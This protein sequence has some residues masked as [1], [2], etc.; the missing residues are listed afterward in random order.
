MSKKLPDNQA[1]SKLIINWYRDNPRDLPWRDTQDPY[2]IWLSEIILQQTRVAQ[3]MPYFYKFSEAYPTVKDLAM[4]PEEEVLRLWQGLGYYSRARNLHFC[5]KQ[6]W[7]ELGGNFPDN[8]K[9]LLKLKGVGSYTA[10]AISS[11]AFGEAKAVVDGNVFR[12]LSRFFG[13]QTDIATG[14]AKKEFEALANS[15]IPKENPGEFNQ[16]MMDFGSRQCTPRN[17]DCEACP[18]NGSCFAFKNDLIQVLPIKI[19]KTKVKERKIH[20]LVLKCGENWVW[21]KRSTGDIWAG[22]YDFPTEEIKSILD[23]YAE[24]KTKEFI[25]PQKE[26][27]HLLSHQR[28]K[29]QFSEIRLESSAQDHLKKLCE[30]QELAMVEE[31]KIDY[32]AKPK[33]IV[34]YLKDQ[35]I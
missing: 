11:F 10:S 12:V 3:G 31:D 1:F 9:D 7:F 4:A 23:K 15:L 32:L 14:K 17:P 6:I 34:N 27:L 35:G 18:L 30:E 20:Y 29:V 28:L 25:P 24:L 22:L 19:K 21:K 26:Y 8:Y 16:A 13:I 5:A 33:L 2:I